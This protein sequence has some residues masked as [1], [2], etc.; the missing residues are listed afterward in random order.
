MPLRIHITH[1]VQRKP[2]MTRRKNFFQA[3]QNHVWPYSRM[4]FLN[5]LIL[6]SILHRPLYNIPIIKRLWTMEVVVVG[7]NTAVPRIF[8]LTGR[9]VCIYSKVLNTP[10]AQWSHPRETTLFATC[11]VWAHD[12]AIHGTHEENW[13]ARPHVSSSN[14]LWRR[15]Y[16]SCG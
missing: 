11:N 8:L 6:P 7:A 15:H 9:L 12:T 1:N 10:W 13:T 3:K 14:L 5:T 2:K 16:F 4:H